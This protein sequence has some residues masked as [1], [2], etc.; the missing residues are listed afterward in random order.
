MVWTDSN[1]KF[2]DAFFLMLDNQGKMDLFPI[3]KS[4]SF[5]NHPVQNLI[6]AE[7]ILDQVIHEDPNYTKAIFLKAIV[8]R[9]LN[10]NEE[11]IL[12]LHQVKDNDFYLYA[13][14]IYLAEYYIYKLKFEEALRYL[15]EVDAAYPSN[16]RVTFLLALVNL[17]LFNFEE[18]KFYLNNFYQFSDEKQLIQLLNRNLNI[19]EEIVLKTSNRLVLKNFKLK[20]INYNLQ[21]KTNLINYFKQYNELGI[22]YDMITCFVYGLILKQVTQYPNFNSFND[23]NV[24]TILNYLRIEDNKV[25]ILLDAIDFEHDFV[26]NFEEYLEVENLMKEDL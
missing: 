25:K 23:Y 4:F 13:C 10:Y 21:L 16:I 2:N 1:Q 22:N 12:Y 17:E 5:K 11:S 8:K 15:K 20:S 19:T 14:N 9:N 6:D 26:K 3:W 7:K 18:A 24:H